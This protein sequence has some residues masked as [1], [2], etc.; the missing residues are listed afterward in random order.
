MA[1]QAQSTAKKKPA[2]KA[3][4]RKS[5]AGK[6]SNKAVRIGLIGYGRAGRSMHIGELSRRKGKFKVVAGY[7]PDKARREK[8]VEE[9]G[10]RVYDSY[11]DLLGDPDVELVDIASPSNDHVPQAVAALKKGFDVFLEKPIAPNTAEAR[12]LVAA[13]KKSKGAL[14]VRH[15]RRF[16]PAFQHIR[17]IIASGILGEVYEIKLR[18]VQYQRR[19]DWQTLIDCGGGQLLNWGPHIIDHGLRFLE[20]PLTDLWSDLKKVAAVGD[21][22]DHLKIVMKGENGRLVDLEISGGSAIPE[23]VYIVSGTRGGLV[24]HDEKTLELRYLDPKQKLSRR[25][26]KKSSPPYGGFGSPDKLKWI[27][28]SI[29]VKPRLKVTTDSIWDYAFDSIRKGKAFPITLEEA[30]QVVDV[31]TRV[32]KG[33]PFD[34]AVK[35]AKKKA[36]PRKRKPKKP[37]RKK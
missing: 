4:S 32:K 3:P 11:E 8:M 36:T 34:P 37:S 10:C 6:T 9:L 19:D 17:E 21:A 15:N 30:L 20:S 35:A 23:P 22:E 13:E 1:K 7:D 2:R 18:R 27:E 28:K 14:Y 33:T 12:K 25:R 26:A 31:Y 29:P 5:S 24:T 16:E